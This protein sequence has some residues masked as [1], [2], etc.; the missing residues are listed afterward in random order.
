MTRPDLKMLRTGLASLPVLG[1]LALLVFLPTRPFLA[2]PIMLTGLL[3]MYTGLFVTLGIRLVSGAL[4]NWVEACKWASAS[5]SGISAL[6]LGLALF[7]GGWFPFFGA[8]AASAVSVI[9]AIPLGTRLAPLARRYVYVLSA[10]G[11]LLLAA[12]ALTIWAGYA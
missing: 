2:G 3:F 12:G 11:N 5:A 6:L 7:V 8:V 9:L 10:L 4:P 1:G